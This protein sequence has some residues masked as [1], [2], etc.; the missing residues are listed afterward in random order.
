MNL[1]RPPPFSEFAGVATAMAAS[2]SRF[3]PPPPAL[4]PALLSPPTVKMES[5]RPV[6]HKTGAPL[7]KTGLLCRR[8]CGIP[9]SSC[10]QNEKNRKSDFPVEK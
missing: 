5:P 7:S 9:A 4:P 8:Q 2:A 10:A 6:D 1:I 3:C